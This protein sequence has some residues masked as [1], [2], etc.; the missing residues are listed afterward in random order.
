MTLQMQ[1]AVLYRPQ[2]QSMAK[3][4]SLHSK[5]LQML[6]FISMQP[7]AR[8]KRIRIVETHFFPFVRFKPE[9]LDAQS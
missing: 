5:P 1:Q 2:T 3:P 8:R 4:Y 9:S 7:N 6:A